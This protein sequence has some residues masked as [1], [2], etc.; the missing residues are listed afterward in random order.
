MVRKTLYTNLFNII[1]KLIV[2]L[3]SPKRSERKV[4]YHCFTRKYIGKLYRER[5]LV[6]LRL[7]L[8]VAI[9]SKNFGA[10]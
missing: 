3:L 7:Y 6:F 2:G 1:L 8:F 10:A 4:A 9:L 5:Y